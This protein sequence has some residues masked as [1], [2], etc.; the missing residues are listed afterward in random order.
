[1]GLRFFADHCIA[2]SVCET[3]RAAGYDVL[4]LPDY[5]PTNAADPDVIATA[6]RLDAILISVNGD[7]AD[8]VRYPPSDY[9]GIVALRLT[10]HP[11]VAVQ[12]V[13][14]L[15]TYLETHPESAHYVGKLLIVEPHQIRIRSR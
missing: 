2:T 15:V 7:F 12:V 1:M 6:Q 10:N 8:I 5:L 14:R 11:K 4:R 13:A 3:L 9:R